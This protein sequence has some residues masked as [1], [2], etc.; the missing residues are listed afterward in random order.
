MEGIDFWRRLLTGFRE[1]KFLVSGAT[2]GVMGFT[3]AIILKE[4]WVKRHFNE[5]YG[6]GGEDG[7]WAGYWFRQGYRAVKDEKFTV[8]HSHKLGFWGWYKQMQHWRSL[9][10]PQPF[11]SLP[12]RKDGPH[13]N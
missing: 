11:H 1:R 5:E 9:N 3:N 7:E 4:L 12:F 2:M 10:K 13:R 6:L 8:R